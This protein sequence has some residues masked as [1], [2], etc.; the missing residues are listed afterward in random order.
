MSWRDAYVVLNAGLKAVSFDSGP[1][2]VAGC[3]V[4]LWECSSG[5]DE[6]C[7]VKRKGGSPLRD[8]EAEVNMLCNMSSW[9]GCEGR[10]WR[11]CGRHCAE[12]AL[13]IL[14]CFYLY[15]SS[16]IHHDGPRV[17]HSPM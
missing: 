15:L 7:L 9:W 13:E 4:N 3:E 8:K 10:R 11:G 12:S 6:H 14:F 17:P 1:P 5:G 2:P 16:S